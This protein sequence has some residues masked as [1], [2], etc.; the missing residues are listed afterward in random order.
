MYSVSMANFILQATA[1][2]LQVPVQ[3]N[4]SFTYKIEMSFEFDDESGG[5][6]FAS[7]FLTAPIYKVRN[8]SMFSTTVLRQ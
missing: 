3:S 5:L 4:F 2:T 1:V 8:L 6:T 7:T